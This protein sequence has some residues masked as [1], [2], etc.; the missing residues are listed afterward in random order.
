LKEK[1]YL[2]KRSFTGESQVLSGA[3]IKWAV[4]S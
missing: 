1:F 4:M 2:G 3:K